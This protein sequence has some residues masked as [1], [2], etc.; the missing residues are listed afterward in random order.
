MMMPIKFVM[1]QYMAKP[2][3]TVVVNQPNMSGIIQSKV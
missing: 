1:S 2:L 3:G